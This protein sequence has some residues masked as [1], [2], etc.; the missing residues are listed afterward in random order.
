MKRQNLLITFLLTLTHCFTQKIPTDLSLKHSLRQ[1]NLSVHFM[2]ADKDSKPVRKFH[3]NK[4]YFWYKSQHVLS[5]QGGAAGSLLDG[6]YESF[7]DNKQLCQKGSFAKG[8]KSGEWISW[9]TDG[10]ILLSE[11]WKKGLKRGEERRYNTEGVLHETILHKKN[12]ALRKNQDSLVKTVYSSSKQWITVY[13]GNQLVQSKE[14]YKK[15]KKHG[16][17]SYYEN[18][19]LIEKQTFRNGEI[20][21]GKKPK[22]EIVVKDSSAVDQKKMFSFLQKKKEHPGTEIKQGENPSKPRK[23]QLTS[24]NE[25]NGGTKEKKQKVKKEAATDSGKKPER[26]RDDRKNN[27]AEQN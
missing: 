20:V 11:Q 7:Y 5:T 21:P 27:P 8:L 15:G 17:S 25:E 23:D 24:G 18:G 1:D 3:K 12:S 10:S 13:D 16:K 4:Y 14:T 9:R 19:K 22:K 6:S 2:V 26:K